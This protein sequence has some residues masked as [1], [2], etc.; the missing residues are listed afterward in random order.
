[1]EKRWA[2]SAAALAVALFVTGCPKSDTEKGGGGGGDMAQPGIG[3]HVQRG[4]E[5]RSL[6][7]DL[8]QLAM[9]LFNPEAGRTPRSWEELKP[10]MQRDA[11]HIVRE[12]EG[13][14]IKVLYNV[15]LSSENIVAYEVQPDLRGSHV[16]AMGDG[17][18][19]TMPTAQLQAALS[20][21]GAG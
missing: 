3:A 5:K 19:H 18:V 4:K 1:M 10:T 12:I 15:P 8:R 9:F 11:P 13:G 6:E 16:V 17:S 20:R 21:Q 7:N 2:W 14:E